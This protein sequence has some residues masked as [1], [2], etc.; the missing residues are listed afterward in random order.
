MKYA[1]YLGCTIPFRLNHYDLSSR[2]VAAALGIELVD[3]PDFSCCGLQ[4]ESISH[5]AWLVSTAYNIC[6]AEELDLDMVL[7]C[8]G[9]HT[10]LVQANE[11]LKKDKNLRDEINEVLKD[12]DLEYKGKIKIKHFV[13]ML[14]RDY[15]ID[16]IKNK[17]KRYFD[18]LKVGAHDG[19]HFLRPSDYVKS[20]DPE[21]PRFLDELIELTGAKSI[22][23]K[24]RLRCCG[25][26]LLAV[27]DAL[28]TR[29]ARE[30][31]KNFKEANVDCIIT[32]C[33]FCNIMQDSQ[34]L[35]I[36]EVYNETYGIPSLLYPQLLG[37]SLGI[38][39][40]ELGLDQNAIP[41]NSIL[42]FLK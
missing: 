9:C 32:I 26:P 40:N 35:K 38:D 12:I 7:L 39:P 37:L 6:K 18:G 31:M 21:M 42:E 1:Y 5:K 13:T 28:A 41:T 24:D 20:D 14:I 4:L 25:G 3:I 27:N 22:K 23:Y 2:K 11:I 17:V 19:C 29:L 10:S 33:P 30:R 16:K 36:K 15:G 8:N 34:Q